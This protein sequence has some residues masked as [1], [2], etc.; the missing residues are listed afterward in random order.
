MFRAL[1]A[2]TALLTALPAHA[3]APLDAQVLLVVPDRAGTLPA[4]LSPMRSALRAKGYSGAHVEARRDVVLQPGRP[5]HV[6]LGRHAVDLELLAT[7]GDQAQVRVTR[8]GQSGK[9]TTVSTQNTR[10]FV[11]VPAK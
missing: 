4:E 11:T 3:A 6:Q 1:L 2:A 10:F 8:E 5:T 9:V 7:G